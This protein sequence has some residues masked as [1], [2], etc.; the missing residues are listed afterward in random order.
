MYTQPEVGAEVADRQARNSRKY[1]AGLER[2]QR[3]RGSVLPYPSQPVKRAAGGRGF[4]SAEGPRMEKSA[5]HG[6][7]GPVLKHTDTRTQAKFFVFF[8]RIEE[9]QSGPY[10]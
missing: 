5:L 1:A 10:S 9:L 8:P 7:R 4:I 3:A 2:G 6:C